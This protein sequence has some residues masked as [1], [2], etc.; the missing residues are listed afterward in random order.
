MYLGAEEFTFANEFFSF[1]KFNSMPE[2]HA[3][4]AEE[5]WQK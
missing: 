1:V 2:T 4:G 5:T 3:A